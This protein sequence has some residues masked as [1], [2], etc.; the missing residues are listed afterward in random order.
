MDGICNVWSAKSNTTLI[1]FTASAAMLLKLVGRNICLFLDLL[2]DPVK[3][4]LL[5]YKHLCYSVSQSAIPSLKSSKC[6]H[7]QTVRARELKFWENF[8]LPI[9][10]ACQL[11]H[12]T[13]Q[14]SPVTCN[15]FLCV[16]K[17]LSLTVEGLLST[18]LLLQFFYIIK[19]NPAYRRH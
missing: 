19:K 12:V 2:T 5:F 8:H 13:C 11:S 1:I 9:N 15:I 6:L 10:V 14:M 16:D 18:G 4:G 3:P 7:S 17:V